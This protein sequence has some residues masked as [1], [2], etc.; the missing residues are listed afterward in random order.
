[1]AT[2]SS[3]TKPRTDENP[4][5][6]G[7]ELRRRP[8]PCVLT[9]FGASGDLT[10]RKIFPALYALAF[11]KLLPENFAVLGVARSAM[12]SEDFVASMEEAVREFG[13]DEF[14]TE[15][16]DALASRTRYLA[17]EVADEEGEDRIAACLGGLDEEFGTRGNRVYYLAV[18]P[19]AMPKLVQELGE[20]RTTTGWTRLIVEKPFGHD[21]GSARELGR[22]PR[23]HLHRGGGLPDR[24]LPREG[25]RPEPP[26]AALRE[27][28]LRAR[29]EPPV[30]RP[31]SDHRGRVDGNREPPP[32]STSR[33]ARSATSFR[34]TSSSWSPSPVWSP[35]S[36]SLPKPSATRS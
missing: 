29:L 1:M 14:T 31:R 12:T 4:L 20:R 22:D 7:L 5:A 10:R 2:Q 34:T 3:A 24:P 23:R 6:E 25:H 32:R 11:R 28:H 27:R 36:T 17:T 9:I 13:R 26:R 19:E 16:W 30:H 21:L 15:A 8:E 18:P 33:R 35:R